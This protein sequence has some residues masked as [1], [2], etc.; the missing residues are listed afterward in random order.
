MVTSRWGGTLGDLVFRI[1]IVASDGERPKLG[2]FSARY[3]SGLLN[4]LTIGLG[5]LIQPFTAKKQA[6]PDL[7]AGTFIVRR[8]GAP[9]TRTKWVL[10]QIG[11]VLL[12]L[13]LG[14]ALALLNPAK[15]L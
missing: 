13:I 2:R 3:F 9:A 12:V 10:I 8:P 15:G 11:T 1:A 6:L 4:V 5:A 7:I 14:T